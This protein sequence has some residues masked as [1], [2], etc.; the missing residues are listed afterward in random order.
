MTDL[1]KSIGWIGLALFGC[2]A[3]L[4]IVGGSRDST[5]LSVLGNGGLGCLLLCLAFYLK[6]RG[7]DGFS[8]LVLPAAIIAAVMFPTG[9]KAIAALCAYIMLGSAGIGG[10]YLAVQVYKK[11]ERYPVLMFCLTLIGWYAGLLTL[12]MPYYERQ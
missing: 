5:L 7:D 10:V 1:Q 11:A 12:V 4:D 3:L 6:S 8:V 9:A 2:A